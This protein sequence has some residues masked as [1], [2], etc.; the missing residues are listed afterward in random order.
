MSTE[1]SWL[2][3]QGV[4]DTELQRE[5][6]SSVEA[7]ITAGA[8]TTDFVKVVAKMQPGVLKAALQASD[9][10]LEA[11]RRLCQIWDVDLKPAPITSHRKFIGPII[12]GCQ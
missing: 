11:L 5:L 9:V 8:F 2:F 3:V 10:Q 1:N 6:R 7:K 12:I 4:V